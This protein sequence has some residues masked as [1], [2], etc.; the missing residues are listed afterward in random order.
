MTIPRPVLVL[1]ATAFARHHR[2]GLAGRS[3]KILQLGCRRGPFIA[4]MR[5][6]RG[7]SPPQTARGPNGLH[8]SSRTRWSAAT[9]I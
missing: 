5:P 4:L 6:L 2:D 1:A 3:P 8:T 9:A 7:F